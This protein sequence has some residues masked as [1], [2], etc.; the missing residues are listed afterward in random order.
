[1]KLQLR[2]TAGRADHFDVAPEHAARVTRAEAFQR[3][4]FGGEAAG[5]VRRRVAAPRGVRDLAVGE[6]S[7]EKPVAEPRDGRFDAVDFRRVHADADN[8]HSVNLPQPSGAFEWVQ[9]PWGRALRCKAISSRHL[10]STSD[11]ELRKAGGQSAAAWHQLAS[12]L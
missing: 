8:I 7:A 4:F 5:Q 10:F 1:M 12:S 2:R 11:L 3:R 9:E 6:N